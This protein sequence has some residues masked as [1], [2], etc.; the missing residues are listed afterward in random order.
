MCTT[1]TKLNITK[2]V[3][4]LAVVQITAPIC[5]ASVPRVRAALKEHD[6]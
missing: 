4:R 1:C 2:V 6:Y 5:T 3:K